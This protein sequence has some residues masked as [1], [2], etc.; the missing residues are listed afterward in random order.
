MGP[1]A[2]VAILSSG[3]TEVSWSAQRHSSL[4]QHCRLDI[5]PAYCGLQRQGVNAWFEQEFNMP[6][7]ARQKTN[8]GWLLLLEASHGHCR[9]RVHR[10]VGMPCLVANSISV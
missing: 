8:A 4:E 10:D 3:G 2:C 9:M 7:M 1:G 6:T 5:W